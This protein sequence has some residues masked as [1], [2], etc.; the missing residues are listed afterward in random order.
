MVVQPTD[1]CCVEVAIFLDRAAKKTRFG[2]FFVG[3]VAERLRSGHVGLGGKLQDTLLIFEE[4][5]D[6][7]PHDAPL[8]LDGL[9]AG[10]FAVIAKQSN[11]RL[12]AMTSDEMIVVLEA[13]L[14]LRS[15]MRGRGMGFA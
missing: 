6:A 15:P 13:E 1:K 12:D 2:G 5:E 3:L 4:A 14:R 7:F 9:T 11:M 10:D 8:W